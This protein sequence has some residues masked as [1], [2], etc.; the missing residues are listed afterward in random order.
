MSNT[1]YGTSRAMPQNARSP[2]FKVDAV[3]QLEQL[4]NVKNALVAHG[5]N[6]FAVTELRH[7][8]PHQG[9]TGCY[10]GIVYKIPFK[11]Q[12]HVEFN[13]AA[14][15]LDTAIEC[16]RNAV[17]TT[18]PSAGKIFVTLLADIIEISFDRPVPAAQLRTMQYPSPDRLQVAKLDSD[19]LDSCELGTTLVNA[20][21]DPGGMP[22]MVR[23]SPT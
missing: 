3:I 16:I 5:F 23:A 4:D 21:P 19:D 14:A 13:V 10:R 12:I 1:M 15:A 9:Q 8:D 17:H 7:H 11:C 18:T 6:E 2:M 22:R 20:K